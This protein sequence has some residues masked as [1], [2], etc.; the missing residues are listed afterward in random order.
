MGSLQRLNY[1]YL[2]TV[3][4]I[5]GTNPDL[6]NDWKDS[7]LIELYF[8]AKHAIHRG[9]DNPILHAEMIEEAKTTALHILEVCQLSRD[10]CERLWLEFDDEYFLRHSADEIAWHTQSI[11][12]GGVHTVPRVLIRQST[13]RGST[14]IFIY[15]RDH[16]HLFAHITTVLSRLGLDILDARI[17]T[18]HAGYTLDTF[19]VLGESGKPVIEDYRIDEITQTLLEMLRNPHQTPPEVSRR[20]SRK[21]R[22][23]SVPTS[24]RFGNDPKSNTTVMELTTA[25]HPGLLSKV[26]K[27]FI[28]S[29]VLVNNARITTIGARAEDVFYITGLDRQPINTRRHQERIRASIMQQLNALAE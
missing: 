5:R 26:G 29:D 10:N 4:D 3:A 27:G 18:T 12:Q 24:I 20:A 28:E 23:F 21:A 25:D 9:F 11:L 14:E 22:Y 6:W 17:I 1:L 15:T 2:L 16:N 19:M 13:A 8:A 7:L